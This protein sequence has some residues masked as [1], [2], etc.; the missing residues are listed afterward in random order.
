MG[1]R[2]ASSSWVGTTLSFGT[3][4][5]DSDGRVVSADPNIVTVCKEVSLLGFR[6]GSGV[7]DPAS[8][9]CGDLTLP[10]NCWRPQLLYSHGSTSQTFSSP[11]VQ[12]RLFA[13]RCVAHEWLSGYFGH[14]ARVPRR[15]VLFHAFIG[16][17]FCVSRSENW[18]RRLLLQITC[19][20]PAV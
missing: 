13:Y 10:C 15:S 8:L 9:G 12:P 17:R 18:R 16:V 5:P 6:I 4:S 2:S 19:T 20:S 3:R 11:P 1:Q 7:A 14:V